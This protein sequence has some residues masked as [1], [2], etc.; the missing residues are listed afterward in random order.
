M[1]ESEREAAEAERRS[2]AGQ[3]RLRLEEERARREAPPRRLSFEER[4]VAEAA[5]RE[6]DIDLAEEK[7]WAVPAHSEE[8]CRWTGRRQEAVQE[9]AKEKKYARYGGVVDKR[10]IYEQQTAIRDADEIIAKHRDRLKDLRT[11]PMPCRHPFVQSIQTCFHEE[12]QF[13]QAVDPDNQC[14]G[15]KMQQLLRVRSV[16]AAQA[17]R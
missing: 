11:R 8:I 9:I 16:V 17:P 14:H 15:E 1:T 2:P 6:R 13:G 4:R 12:L 7:E 10:A 3:E 5:A